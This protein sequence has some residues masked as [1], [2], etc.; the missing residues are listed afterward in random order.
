MSKKDAYIQKV[1]AKIEE[2]TAKLK[3]LQAKAK[4]NVADQK[5][6]AYDQ[7]EKLEKTLDNAKVRLN[8]VTDAAE[9]KWESLTGRLDA[10]TE[11]VT[12]SA[13]KLLGK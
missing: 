9:D 6:M 7:I 4:G 13:K 1:Q 3:G 12:A 5:L 11:E 2:Q 8:E 10:L